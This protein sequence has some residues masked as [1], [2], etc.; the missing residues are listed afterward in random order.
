MAKKILTARAVETAK[1]KKH[2]RREIPDG[3]GSGLY[4]SIEASGR[5]CWVL[6]YRADGRQR[7]RQIGDVGTM[8][9]AAA[10]A[11]AASA[12]HQRE[13][14]ATPTSS[15]ART[16]DRVDVMA[17]RF[18]ELHAYRKTRA[19]T[20]WASERIFNRLILPAWGSRSIG[21]IT[22]RDVIALVE[23]VATDRPYLANRTLS[24]LSKFF[25]WLCSRGEISASPVTGVERPFREEVRQ[26]TL[27]DPELRAI[28]LACE[29]DGPFGDA[30]RLLILT[31]A[32][33]NEVSRM[34]WDEVDEDRR[35][36]TLPRERAKNN[37]EH[38][39][40]LSRQSWTML[41]SV[42]RF[43]G[44][45]YVF[46]SDGSGPVA[47]W[48]KAKSRL[49]A[50]AGLVEDSWRLHDI[51]RTAASGMQRLGVAVP[52][53]EKALNHVSGTFSGI[54]S[55]YQTSDYANEI[56]AALQKWAD[57]VTSKS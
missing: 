12:R 14:G 56:R 3:T 37:R 38:A 40:P 20:A 44:C 18:L 10:R 11:A 33:R 28:W 35:L 25:G 47:G 46:S 9:L 57:H 30:V 17:G 55:T 22:R 23:H 1:A 29:D 24:V 19:S 15:V 36:W 39:V 54:V 34:R 51:R 21:E 52:V 49:S 6:R 4:L 8:S 27:S 26:R 2:H 43:A 50:K 41:Q 53:I 7:R 32:R 31:A 48:A 5:K 13:Q 45:P 42:Q 16:G